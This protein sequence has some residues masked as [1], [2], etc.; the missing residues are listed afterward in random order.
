MHERACHRIFCGWY[1]IFVKQYLA[2]VCTSYYNKNIANIRTL[3]CCWLK[4]NLEKKNLRY[5]LVMMR[6]ADR[7][8]VFAL[9]ENVFDYKLPVHLFFLSLFGVFAV[10]EV[11][12]YIP[13]Y[14][15]RL[16]RS[17][18]VSRNIPQTD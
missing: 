2:T 11:Y 6:G 12:S 17:F 18:I 7:S 3:Y 9:D 15:I 1:K 8:R 14:I 13:L 5:R 10:Y 4:I 16:K